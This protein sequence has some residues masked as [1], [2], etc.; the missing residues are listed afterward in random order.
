M[1]TLQ[2]PSLVLRPL[3]AHDEPLFLSLYCD[4]STM[5]H[6]GAAMAPTTAVRAF[7]NALGQ[8]SSG[9]GT[10]RFW[11]VQARPG[12]ESIGVMGLTRIA[13]RAG[14]VGILVDPACR[15]RA[16]AAESI[17]A[18][19]DHVFGDLGDEVLAA[20]HAASN[21]STARL[22][23]KLG[24]ERRAEPGGEDPWHWQLTPAL[25]T[26]VRDRWRGRGLHSGDDG[27]SFLD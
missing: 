15:G 25:W 17:A 1:T 10:Q 12:L 19:A 21:A 9:T 11:C 5:R 22:L 16:F 2:T 24:F 27:L 20:R 26:P 18:L 6:L 3:E 13:A 8:T 4:E 23:T 7:R 14:E